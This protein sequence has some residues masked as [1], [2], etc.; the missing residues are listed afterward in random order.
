[1]RARRP[2][3][4]AAQNAPH[5]Q[6]RRGQARGR[7]TRARVLD[8]AE[9]LFT[10][11]GYDGTSMSDVSHS[12]RIGVGTVYHHFPDKRALLLELLEQWHERLV[13]DPQSET[14]LQRFL[15]DD[16]KAAIGGWLR[17]SYERLRE[18]PSL[19]LVALAFSGRDAE[20]E[21]CYRRIESL[22]IGR[23]CALIRYGQAQGLMRED[24]D[25]D[26]AAFLVHHAIDVAATQ[27]LVRGAADAQRL[28][29]D[30]VVSGL[31]DMICRFLLS[32]P[33]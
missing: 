6:G 8:A 12:A 20:V 10:R 21:A 14:E 26:S 23:L 24:L 29:P 13:A 15:G 3:P 9:D 4:S 27:V 5:K 25:I 28:D 32:D 33:A 18:R 22:G 7:V 11:Q 1:M 31:A 16:P 30:L 19:Y 2:P 17:A